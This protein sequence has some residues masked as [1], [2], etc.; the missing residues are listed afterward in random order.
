MNDLSGED[1]IVWIEGPE[2]FEYVREAVAWWWRSRR[3][4]IKWSAGRTVGYSVLRADAPHSVGP[5]R[6][7]RRLFWVAEH[8]RGEPGFRGGG[9][10]S[11]AVDPQEVRPGVFGKASNEALL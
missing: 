2:G 10:P 6:F 11:E 5:G 9:P 1:E 7:T 4:P 8:D 3:G